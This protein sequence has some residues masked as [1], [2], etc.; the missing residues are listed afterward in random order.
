MHRA[1]LA[2]LLTIVACGRTPPPPPVLGP[3]P[4]FALTDQAGRAVSRADLR[5]AVWV[6][7]FIFT[8]CPTICPRLTDRMAELA[9]RTQGV[10]FVSF[11]V[12]PEHDTPAALAAFAAAHGADLTRWSFLTGPI[13]AVTAGAKLALERDPAQPPEA[14]IRHGTHFILVDAE[15]RIRDGY[16]DSADEDG[17]ARL[18]ADLAALAR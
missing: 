14:A 13:D 7:D 10:R 11:S 8:R 17:R 3:F 4:D 6:A 16:Y 9:A 5:G 18:R 15:G 12:D 2:V 1:A